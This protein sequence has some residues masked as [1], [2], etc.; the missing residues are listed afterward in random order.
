M[1]MTVEATINGQDNRGRLKMGILGV[2]NVLPIV[3]LHIRMNFGGRRKTS[4]LSKFLPSGKIPTR[5]EGGTKRD[6]RE[7][8]TNLRILESWN[9][10]GRSI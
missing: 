7:T 5:I 2:T 10:F 8:R 1:Q 6:G 3:V 9:T 4:S